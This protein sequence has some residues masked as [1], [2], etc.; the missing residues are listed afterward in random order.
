VG[1]G[2]DHWGAVGGG[3]GCIRG[4]RDGLVIGRRSLDRVWGRDG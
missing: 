3:G 2:G 1:G 4:F